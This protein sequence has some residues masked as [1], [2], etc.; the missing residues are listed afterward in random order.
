MKALFDPTDVI[1]RSATRTEETRRA[2]PER[3][4][5]SSAKGVL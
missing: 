4:A 1:G 3:C 5:T 2:A